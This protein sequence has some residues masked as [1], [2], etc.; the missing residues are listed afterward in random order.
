M[1]SPVRFTS[2][3]HTISGVALFALKPNKAFRFCPSPP[4]DELS[5]EDHTRRQR[6]LLSRN[7]KEKKQCSGFRRVLLTACDILD[8]K[9]YD[10]YGHHHVDD[11]Q[12]HHRQLH[13]RFRC[14][15]I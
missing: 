9:I 10:G 6:A 3:L 1:I 14:P 2:Y 7:E 12:V 13:T 5:V 4:L 11:F 8:D 15:R